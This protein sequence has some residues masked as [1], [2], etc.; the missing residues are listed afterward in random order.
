MKFRTI[1]R[2]RPKVPIP[3]SGQTAKMCEDEMEAIIRE[4]QICRAFRFLVITGSLEVVKDQTE[5]S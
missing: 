3:D 1:I 4:E 5:S 2:L